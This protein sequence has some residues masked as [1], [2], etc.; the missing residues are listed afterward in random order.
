MTIP[1]LL[2]IASG[3]ALGALSR[4]GLSSLIARLSEGS[5]FPLG[6]LICNVL[7]S[8]LM[9]V[10]IATLALKGQASEQMR[11]FLSVGFLGAFTTFST[12]SLETVTL[13]ER[14]AYT[15]AGLYIVASVA[16]SVLFLFA[17]MALTKGVL[18]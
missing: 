7:G 6:I 13:I 17:G 4:H 2:A 9:G 5:A 16:F 18:S 1:L 8:F 15:Q 3:G 10:L 14:G 12:F 11:A